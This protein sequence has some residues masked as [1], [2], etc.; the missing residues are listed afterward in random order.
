MCMMFPTDCCTVDLFQYRICELVQKFGILV[1]HSDKEWG[2]FV[3]HARML[4]KIFKGYCQIRQGLPCGF[5][6]S[7]EI[8][9]TPSLATGLCELSYSLPALAMR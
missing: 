3:V 6:A 4:F 9:D 1:P 2:M 7:L 5:D 8:L